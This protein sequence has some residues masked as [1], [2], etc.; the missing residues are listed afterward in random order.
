M[1]TTKLFTAADMRAA[2]EAAARAGV[3]LQILMEAAGRAVADAALKHWPDKQH[4][5]VLCGKGNNGGDGYVAARYLHLRGNRVTV[6][7][8]AT[9]QDAMSSAASRAARAAWLA[10]GSS[11]K[12]SLQSLQ[13]SLNEAEVVIDALFGSGLARA[14]NGDLATVVETVN[15]SD[16]PVLSVDVPSGVNAELPV[17]IGPHIC[18]TRTVQLAGPKLA[19]AFAPAKAAFGRWEVVDIG[20]P[21]ELLDKQST[22]E[23]LNDETVNAWLPTRAL[24]AHKYTAGTV[25]VVA[26]S[27]RYLGAAELAA[28][29]A[30]RA[31]AGL[32]TLAAEARLPNSWPEIIFETLHWD[33]KPLETLAELGEKRAQVRVIGPGLDDRASEL[34]PEIIAQSNVPTVLDAGALTGGEAWRSAVKKHGRCVITPHTGEAAKLLDTSSKEIGAKPLEM[35]RKLADTFGAVAVL[36]GATTVIAEPGGR[37]LV[38]ATGHPGMA[39]GGAGDVLA[40]MIGAW[41]AS[42]DDPTTRA[43]AAV[44]VHGLA[45]EGAAQHYGDSLLA[46][47]LVES[48]P[49]A[50]LKLRGEY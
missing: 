17:F 3:A 8:Q 46:S 10:L 2:D 7:E 26:G 39:T 32:V 19:S 20:I 4:F 14:L 12:L 24:D 13:E 25:L 48:F 43:A 33:N 15:R 31:G 11:R 40:G 1:T 50:W 34:L 47:D 37:V 30:Y 18:A 21:A 6:L 36:K 45:G 35:A 5:L 28:R 22:V 41:L 23:L 44:Y 29:G 38:S 42:A 49:K 9:S 16:L 27:R